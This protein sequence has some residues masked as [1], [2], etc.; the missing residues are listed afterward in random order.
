MYVFKLFFFV[1]SL[2]VGNKNIFVMSPSWH[3]L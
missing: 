1:D 2:A 3:S